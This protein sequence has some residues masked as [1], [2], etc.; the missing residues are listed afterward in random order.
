MGVAPGADHEVCIVLNGQ[1]EPR[2]DT[3][4]P[5]QAFPLVSRLWA[6]TDCATCNAIP[7]TDA[8]RCPLSAPLQN[9]VLHRFGDMLRRNIIHPRR[10]GDRPRHPYTSVG[11]PCAERKRLHRLL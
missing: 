7:A 5:S 10:V 2:C 6:G 4:H 11:H 1:D 8:Q 9:L 3:N